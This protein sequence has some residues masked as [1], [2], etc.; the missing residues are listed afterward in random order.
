MNP[1]YGL[2]AALSAGMMVFAVL[3]SWWYGTMQKRSRQYAVIAGRAYRPRLLSLNRNALTAWLF[4]GLYFVL[5]KLIPIL[6]VAWASFLPFFQLPS[7]HAFGLLSL[8][9]YRGLPWNLALAGLANTANSCR[10]RT[11]LDAAPCACVFLG[12][13]A[14]VA[15]LAQPLRCGRLPAPCDPR[16]R[17]LGIGALLIALYALQRI[18]PIYGT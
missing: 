10:Y 3:L 5:S 14:L 11:N 8:T 18:V 17:L 4:L 2:A 12:G 6:T 15:A 13:V 9:Q 16:Q 7:A 1:R